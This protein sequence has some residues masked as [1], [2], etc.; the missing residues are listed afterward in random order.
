MLPHAMGFLEMEDRGSGI[1]D[2]GSGIGDRGSG[3]KDEGSRSEDRGVRIEDRERRI[4]VS[5]IK[6]QK[7]DL[8][9]FSLLK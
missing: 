6:D 3:I 9:H 7:I 1:G 8:F 2:R 5:R 4:K